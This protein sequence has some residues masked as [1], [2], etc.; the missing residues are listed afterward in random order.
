MHG[1]EIILS[2]AAQPGNIPFEAGLARTHESADGVVVGNCGVG[3]SD[4]GS[5]SGGIGRECLG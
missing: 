2:E 5:S 1:S 4:R 3:C